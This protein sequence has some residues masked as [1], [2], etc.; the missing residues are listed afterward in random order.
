VTSPGGT[1]RATDRAIELS[2]TGK[3]FADGTLALDGVDLAVD[4]GEFVSVVGPSGCGK[5]TL[6]RLIAGLDEPTSGT[7]SRSSDNIAY[8][9]QEPTLLPWRTVRANVE[10]VAELNRVPRQRRRALAQD[11]LARVGLADFAGHRPH[12]L[13]GGMR[14]RAA[15][16]QALTGRPELFVF[17]EP[18]GAVD[19]LTRN[20]LCE[21]LHE[22]YLAERFA[23]VFVTHSISEAV[24]LAGRVVVLSPR[25]GR[26]SADIE[27]PLGF[28][29]RPEMRYSAGFADIAGAVAE[30][31]AP[32]AASDRP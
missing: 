18:F 17:D 9:F 4:A 8:V 24:Y 22:L 25:P 27:V 26:V 12:Q 30:H 5:T 7:V 14:M 13:S 31:L 20:L 32:A 16:A 21:Q 1:G 29:R 3:R 2:G 28:P 6:L 15:L 19:E 23:G 10:L 11:A